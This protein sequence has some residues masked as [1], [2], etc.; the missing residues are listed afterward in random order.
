MNRYWRWFRMLAVP[1]ALVVVLV[2]IGEPWLMFPGIARRGL[3]IDS[4]GGRLETVSI[5]TTDDQTLQGL[6]CS[7]EG[8]RG[9]I[10]ICHGNGD[11]LCF[12]EEEVLFMGQ[13]FNMAV[14]A[15]DYRGFGNSEGFPSSKRLYEDGQAVYDYAM[16]QG[17]P[18]EKVVVFGRSLGGAIAVSIASENKVAGL[19]LQSTFS[20]ITEVAARKFFWL[21]VRWL[22]RNQFPSEEKIVNYDGPLVQCHGTADRVV[23]FEFG[24]KLHAAATNTSSKVFVE[25]PGRGHNNPPT[26]KFWREFAK[27]LDECL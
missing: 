4:A 8:S 20:S 5:P 1:Y 14:L 13:E 17:F 7:P 23:P 25:E 24:E 9:L 3:E 12:M 26:D 21:P 27:M 2:A 16:E 10:I 6:L 18:P 19:G 15:F 22:I 11:L